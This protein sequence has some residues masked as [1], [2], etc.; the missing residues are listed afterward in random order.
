VRLPEYLVHWIVVAWSEGTRGHVVDY[1]RIEVASAELGVEKALMVALR[2][3]RD[4]ALAGW[5][6]AAADAGQ[7]ERP[8]QV[9]IDAG[10]MANV[11]YEF[12]R[13]QQGQNFRPTV[14]R[15]ADQQRRQ[16]YNRP[17]NTGSIV[18]H[19]G[20]GFHMNHLPAERLFLVEV[21]SDHWKTWVHQ[22]LGTPVGQP[23]SLTFYQAP[24]QEHLALAKHLTAERKTEEFVV[25]R[26]VT[27]KW[28]RI[29]KQNHWF[30]ALYNACAAGYHAGVRLV[31]DN[32]QRRLPPH[33]RPTCQQL[34]K[35]TRGRD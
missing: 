9:W 11:V 12:C 1:G 29:R 35:Q 19:I 27:I 14:G 25:G 10:Y 16:W 15:G 32:R 20:E 22:R 4:L 2:E 17:T 7:R 3:F 6:V 18:K 24:P 28:E 23:G 5:P 8:W 26:G 34:L 21:D 13:K 30:D 33:L 31:E